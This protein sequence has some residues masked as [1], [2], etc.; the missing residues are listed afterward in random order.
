MFLLQVLQNVRQTG[1]NLSGIG[2]KALAK[3]SV[4]QT[5]KDAVVKSQTDNEAANQVNLVP[6]F[7]PHFCL[8]KGCSCLSA[9]QVVFS[10]IF[11]VVSGAGG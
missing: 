4:K 7:P 9:C 6:C 11:P 1:S 5:M 8:W 3:H 10:L 2:Y